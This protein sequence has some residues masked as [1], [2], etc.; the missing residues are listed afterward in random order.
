MSIAAPAC[1]HGSISAASITTNVCSVI[2]TGVPGIGTA[3]AA[4]AVHMSTANS[5]GLRMDP[6]AP[7]V[8]V[9]SVVLSVSIALRTIILLGCDCITLMNRR[10][11]TAEMMASAKVTKMQGLSTYAP[12]RMLAKFR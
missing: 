11:L 8:A 9:F 1:F 10:L 5:A 3:P 7:L 4:E 12:N 6:T 2:G